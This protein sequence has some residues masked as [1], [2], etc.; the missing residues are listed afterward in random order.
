M[1]LLDLYQLSV[2]LKMQLPILFSFAVIRWFA[3]ICASVWCD[4]FLPKFVRVRV[5]A[6]HEVAMDLRRYMI[7]AFLVISL[8]CVVRSPPTDTCGE[9]SSVRVQGM[10]CAIALTVLI[11]CNQTFP[12][13]MA[14]AT[15]KAVAD[16]SPA[17]LILAPATGIATFASENRHTTKCFVGFLSICLAYSVECYT[18]DKATN[19]T[20][21]P[22]LAIVLSIAVGTVHITT[23]LWMSG[24]GAMRQGLRML[25]TTGSP[26]PADSD[27]EDEEEEEISDALEEPMPPAPAPPPSPV[28]RHRVVDSGANTGATD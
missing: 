15:L 21:G 26:R 1:A 9:Y 17:T 24:V 11:T 20:G 4:L 13:A 10:G 6:L 12:L 5:D 7:I 25:L 19:R 18:D 14:L 16:V 8:V 27:D 22:I 28:L 2:M 23:A 3:G